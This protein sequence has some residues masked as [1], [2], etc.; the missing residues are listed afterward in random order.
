MYAEHIIVNIDKITISFYAD[1]TKTVIISDKHKIEEFMTDL[2]NAQ[3]AG[4]WKGAH[5]DK[6]TLEYNDGDKKTFHTNGKVFGQNGSQ[7]FHLN[8]K[9]QKYWDKQL[10]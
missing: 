9:Y 5:W 10:S 8:E 6:I 2:H 4:L 1:T 3:E 7:F